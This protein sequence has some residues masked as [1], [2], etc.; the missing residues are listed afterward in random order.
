MSR[1]SSSISDST[2]TAIWQRHYGHKTEATCLVCNINRI[3][4]KERYGF[5]A[6]HIVAHRWCHTSDSLYLVPMCSACNSDMRDICLF[7][8]LYG[9]ERYATIQSLAWSIFCAVRENNHHEVTAEYQDHCWRVIFQLYASTRFLEG[10]LQNKRAI[11]ELLI[12]KQVREIKKR[13]EVQLIKLE[14][15][16]NL[17]YTLL[18][19]K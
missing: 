11:R 19:T 8:Y 6:G 13:I 10:A 18:T 17:M 12:D 1:S 4:L 16:R 14:K 9:R 5:E 3:G 2:R 15:Q 7:D